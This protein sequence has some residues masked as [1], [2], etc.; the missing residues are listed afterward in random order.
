M[1]CKNCFCI[2]FGKEICQLEKRPLICMALAQT[3]LHRDSEE[4]LKQKKTYRPGLMNKKSCEKN[5]QDFYELHTF[6]RW[7][8]PLHHSTKLSRCWER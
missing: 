5:S 8:I 1:N 2:Y 6:S 7:P 4:T 3:H